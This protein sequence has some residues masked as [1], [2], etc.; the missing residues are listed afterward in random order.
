MKQLSYEKIFRGFLYPLYET[1]IRKRSTFRYNQEY[2]NNQWK[3][4]DEIENLQWYKIKSL[5]KHSYE[6]VSYY[7]KKMSE[8]GIEPGDIKTKEEYSSLPLLTKKDIQENYNALIAKNFK[9][10]TRTK[11]TGGSTGIPMQFE[12]NAES[13]QRRNAVMWRGY[14]WAGSDIGRKSLY[15]WGRSIEH[16]GVHKIVK[17]KY[18]NIFLRRKIL[19]SFML[20]K[21]TMKT[22]ITEINSY[23]PVNIIG[24]VA[25]L[26]TIAKY[27]ENESCMVH[28]PKSIISAA[29]TLHEFQREYLEKVFDCPVFNTYGCREFML[30]AGE[31]E[32]RNGLHIN[33]DHL[34]VE[35]VDDQG[36]N[37][38]D[39]PGRVVVTDL[40]NYGM[41]FM[42][43]LNGDI[44]ETNGNT[45][46]CGRGLP[47][48]ASV[49]G[50]EMDTINT[51][52]G[53]V[54]P[55][56]FFPHLIKEVSSVYEFQVR[57]YKLDEIKII[58]VPKGQIN[59]SDENYLKKKILD[60]LGKRVKIEFEYVDKIPRTETGKLRVTLSCLQK[61]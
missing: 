32:K 21:E 61:Y 54:V 35:T 60:T 15:L 48:L 3:S 4:K 13:D 39:R 50:R 28:R 38:K 19:D 55:G 31:C 51:P 23:K 44:A 30:I 5:L 10:K 26:M 52:D 2:E 41:P 40:H 20:S 6:N 34:F 57:Q 27:I 16:G 56:E 53:R 7:K 36:K 42:R 43:Y 33:S 22:F 37:V 25:S 29:E 11:K 12:F 8:L 17:D 58:I 45:C 49:K 18:Y 47:M 14:R 1:K 9:N 59:R 24:Y 46:D